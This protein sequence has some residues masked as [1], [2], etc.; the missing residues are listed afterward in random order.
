MWGEPSRGAGMGPPVTDPPQ[1][2]APS[3]PLHWVPCCITCCPLLPRRVPWGCSPPSHRP[4]VG[5]RA[6]PDVD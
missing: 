1:L 4:G 3:L 5:S 2:Y 6:H